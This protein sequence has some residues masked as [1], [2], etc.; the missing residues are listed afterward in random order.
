MKPAVSVLI[1]TRNRGDMLHRLLRTLDSAQAASS[2]ATQ[3]LIA[4]NASTDDT[5][6][7]L[8]AWVRAGSGREC[9]VVD[10]V[11]KSR[12]LN[13]L[14][15][16]ARAPLLAFTDDDVEVA[17]DWFDAIVAFFAAYG[18]FDAV[19]GRVLGPPGTDAELLARAAYYETVPLFDAGDAVCEQPRLY[20][21]NMVVRRHVF[22]R[23]GGFNERLGP[24]A[25]GL[26][27]DDELAERILLADM[28]IGYTPYIRA[29]HVVESNR[30]TPAYYR[31][32]QLRLARGHF[33]RGALRPLHRT[34]GRL[35]DSSL[36]LAW[37]RL[38]GG[39]P[40]RWL[41]AWGRVIRHR[42]TVRLQWEHRTRRHH[43]AP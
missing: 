29:Y 37:Y 19:M 2:V 25:S 7:H 24:G 18:H 36:A 34:L 13:R 42:E 1:A 27:D 20:G 35:V 41:R 3:I 38:R 28:R 11:G 39:D 16:L 6:A 4:D 43:T 9:I 21:C 10:G 40:R 8:A 14:L 17:A 26:Q 15:P 22:E 33:V 31:L 32:H 23:L 30:L 5:P 12:A